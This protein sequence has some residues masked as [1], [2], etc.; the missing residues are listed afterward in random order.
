MMVAFSGTSG[1]LTGIRN[2]PTYSI[3]AENKNLEINIYPYL[4]VY[5]SFGILTGITYLVTFPF[6]LYNVYKIL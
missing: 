5:I 3:K 1:L 4:L 6:C 2:Y